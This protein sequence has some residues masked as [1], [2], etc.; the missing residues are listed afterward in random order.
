MPCLRFGGI[1]DAVDDA[2]ISFAIARNLV[3]H[4]VLSHDLSAPPVEGMTNLLWTLLS[5]A[6]IAVLPDL[7]PIGP[8]RLLGVILYAATGWHLARVVVRASP[9]GTGAGPGLLVAGL[10]LVSGNLAY[11]AVS[12]LET[13]LFL[14]LAVLGVAQLQARRWGLAGLALG[15]L[16]ATRPE[17]VLVGGLLTGAVLVRERRPALRLGLVFGLLVA[18]LEIFRLG[19]YGDLVPNTFHAKAPVPESGIGYLGRYLLGGLGGVGLVGALP[20][21]R[22]RGPLL[23]AAVLVVL[24]LGVA[25]SG[26]DWMPGFRRMSLVHL[27]IVGLLGLSLASARGGRARQLVLAAAAVVGLAQVRL[28]VLGQDSATFPHDSL[29]ALAARA[30][31]SAGVETVALVDIGRFGW[32]F[33]GR[34]VDLVGLTDA[35]LARLPGGHADKPWDEDWFRA[36]GADVLVARSET[37]VADPLVSAPRLGLPERGMVRSVLDHG[38]YHLHT[39]MHPA[40]GQWWL[41]FARDGLDL[42]EAE[43]GA[44]S[45]KDLRQLLVEAAA[46]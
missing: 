36:K 29:D 14:F 4:G 19:Y 32:R 34:V 8:A 20:A 46:P 15:L 44:R 11:Y 5:A 40:E 17:G 33:D 31:A 21:L 30:N 25:W 23:V 7:D 45:E 2:W 10:L 9:Q 22:Q 41:I 12:G 38:G 43:W 35:H 28:G 27:G 42:P 3:R 1:G 39:V 16:A 26:G 13:P 37:P 18:T 6:W 24:A